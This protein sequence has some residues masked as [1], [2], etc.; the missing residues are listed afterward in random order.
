MAINDE[1]TNTFLVGAFNFGSQDELNESVH[2]V[3]MAGYPAELEDGK[4]ANLLVE[5]EQENLPQG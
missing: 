4:I 5:E 3:K 2:S 1:G